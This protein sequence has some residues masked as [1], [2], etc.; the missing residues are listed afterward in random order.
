MGDHFRENIKL[1]I[2]L[3]DTLMSPI[4]LY[5]NEMRGIDHNCNGKIDR[6]LPELVQNKLLKWVLRVKRYCIDN[7][8]RALTGSQ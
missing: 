5:G 8:C 3:I 4:L 2:K 1:T 7:A 6:D